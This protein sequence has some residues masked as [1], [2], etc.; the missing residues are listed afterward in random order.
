M[1]HPADNG[2]AGGCVRAGIAVGVPLFF[3][4]APASGMGG[5]AAA[6]L[7]LG[8]AAPGELLAN[9]VIVTRAPKRPWRFTFAGYA[10][11]GV[12]LALIGLALGLLA[13]PLLVAAIMMLSF[14]VGVGNAL[15]GLQMVT[16]FGTWLDAG[17][18]A[19]VLRLR[20][21]LVTGAAVAST[22]LGPWLFT[23]LGIPAV[24]VACGACLAV[25]AQLASRMGEAGR[26]K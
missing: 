23:A 5:L 17:D 15:A 8:A 3:A 7:A 14:L 24:V 22:G 13:P 26:G 21:V 2:R 11:I 1:V 6:A 16:F 9:A 20:L 19:A 4:P 12:A 25:T 18:F 10:G